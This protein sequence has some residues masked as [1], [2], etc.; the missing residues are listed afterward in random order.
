MFWIEENIFCIRLGFFSGEK[1][2][3]VLIVPQTY[4]NL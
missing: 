3:S 4:S 1:K 2:I